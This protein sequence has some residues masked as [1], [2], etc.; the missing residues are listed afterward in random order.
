MPVCPGHA[1]SPSPLAQAYFIHDDQPGVT[2]RVNNFEFLRPLVEGL[3]YPFPRLVLPAPL[4][5]RLAFLLECL[6]RALLPLCDLSRLFILTRAEVLKSS[7]CARI[8]GCRAF[9]GGKWQEAS[10]GLTHG[11]VGGMP[12][13]LWSSDASQLRIPNRL[14]SPQDPLVLCG[15]GAPRAGLRPCAAQFQ[16]GGAV[17]RR[18][19]PRP[20]ATR[21]ET[22]GRCTAPQRARRG[23]QNILGAAHGGL[24]SSPAATCPHN[25]DWLAAWQGNRHVK[26][27]TWTRSTNAPAGVAGGLA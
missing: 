26:L 11:V 7:G 8:W 12:P 5:Y 20:A 22:V 3:G 13:H 17:V 21:T 24:C 25:R 9:S 18:Q 19:G 6:H 15:Q 1:T 14:R 23:G 4:A 10:P 16:A 2:S 27:H